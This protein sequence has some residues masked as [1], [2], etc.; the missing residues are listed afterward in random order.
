MARMMG[1]AANGFIIQLSAISY[2]L[3]AIGRPVEALFAIR[4]S[5]FFLPYSSES[6]N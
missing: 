6:E 3:S 5:V 1:L 4:S 2:Q